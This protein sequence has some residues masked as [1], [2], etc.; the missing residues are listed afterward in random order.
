MNRLERINLKNWDR[1]NEALTLD[2]K[3]GSAT[4]STAHI[5]HGF[6]YMTPD[7]AKG[8]DLPKVSAIYSMHAALWLQLDN[9]RWNIEDVILL[10]D[11]KTSGWCD[12]TIIT[13]SKPVIQFTYPG[14]TL[15]PLNR[16][17]PSFDGLDEE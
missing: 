14:S 15:D 7:Q 12:F 8:I 11:S 17:D 2:T 16:L 6:I 9:R 4:Q 10:H 5:C 13:G 3:T 1:A